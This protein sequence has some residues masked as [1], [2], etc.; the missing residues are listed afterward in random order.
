MSEETNVDAG[1]MVTGMEQMEKGKVGSMENGES[2][3][4]PK[5]L[6]IDE[7]VQGEQEIDRV[8]SSPGGSFPSLS[9]SQSSGS[10]KMIP[11]VSPIG[12]VSVLKFEDTLSEE[13]CRSFNIIYESLLL[14]D[15]A[16]NLT[17]L[18]MGIVLAENPLALLQ[19]MHERLK[20]LIISSE[21]F[22]KKRE[23]STLLK[24]G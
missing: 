14:E 3:K 16:G 9:S 6:I 7:E 22:K 19:V 4:S 18:A 10:N 23:L 15:R 13:Y 24:L 12:K 2:P 8:G 17:D 11:Y 20:H 5:K 1:M 21:T